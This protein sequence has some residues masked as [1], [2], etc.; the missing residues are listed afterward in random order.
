MPR[1][2]YNLHTENTVSSD[3]RAAF[4]DAFLENE[5]LPAKET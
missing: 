2:R 4:Q 3:L 5:A 1:P